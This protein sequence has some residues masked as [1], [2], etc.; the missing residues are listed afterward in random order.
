MLAAVKIVVMSEPRIRLRMVSS[1]GFIRTILHR[2]GDPRRVQPTARR[3]PQRHKE[4]KEELK[5]F[6]LFV[7]L[8]FSTSAGDRQSTFQARLQSIARLVSYHSVTPL[9]S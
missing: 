6:V 4:H 7:S 5:N 3:K 9:N 1:L 2:S 8:W